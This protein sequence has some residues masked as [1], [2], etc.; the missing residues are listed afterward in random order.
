MD[1]PRRRGK[2]CTADPGK[3][4]KPTTH[5]AGVLEVLERVVGIVDLRLYKQRRLQGSTLTHTK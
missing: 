4:K 3:V 1:P 2:D 5:S